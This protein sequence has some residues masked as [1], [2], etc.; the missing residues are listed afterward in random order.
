[1]LKITEK[2][3]ISKSKSQVIVI[4]QEVDSHML[5]NGSKRMKYHI[6]TLSERGKPG[7]RI[8]KEREG[9]VKY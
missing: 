8:E 7:P 6:C 3:P 1:M 9:V 4:I 5:T 2:Y